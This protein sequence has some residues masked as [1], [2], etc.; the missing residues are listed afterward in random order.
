MQTQRRQKP[1][2]RV[3]TFSE[4]VTV[5]KVKPYSEVY[6]V[7]PRH[8]VYNRHGLKLIKQADADRFT[9]KSP[10]I[11]LR[12]AEESLEARTDGRLRRGQVL[13]KVLEQGAA[14]EIQTDVKLALIAAVKSPRKRKIPNRAGAKKV[15]QFEQL[16][17]PGDELNQTEATSFGALA[18]RANYLAQDRPDIAFASKELCRE[19]AKPSK[20]S[21]LKLKRLARY[22]LGKPRLVWRYDYQSPTKLLTVFVDTDFAGCHKTRRSTSGGCGMIGSHLIKAWSTTQTVIALSS[23]EAELT[24][25]VKGAAQAIGLRSVAADLGKRWAVDIQADATAAIGICRRKGLGKIRHLA[26]ADLWVQDKIKTGDFSLTKVPG[27]ENPADMLTKYLDGQSI[28]KHARRISMMYED[29]RAESAPQLPK[30]EIPEDDDEKNTRLP[31]EISK[32]EISKKV[33]ATSKRPP[34]VTLQ[35]PPLGTKLSGMQWADVDDSDEEEEEESST[36]NPKKI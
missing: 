30:N 34:N 15:K 21:Y 7:H 33:D 11:M 23:G 13:K 19:F 22:L 9:G 32:S 25:I 2:S 14:W 3:I 16:V 20:S 17:S 6:P 28:D 26:V 24:G 29:G 10:R 5:H 35:K 4:N 12:R 1:D 18:A 8:F 31:S 27:P 36:T